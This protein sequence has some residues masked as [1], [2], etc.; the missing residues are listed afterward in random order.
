MIQANP[1]ITPDVLK[2][3][4]VGTAKKMGGLLSLGAAGSGAGLIDATAAVNASAA[5][6]YATK[7]AN[8]DLLSVGSTGAGPIQLSRDTSTIVY[9]DLNADG[10]L[11]SVVGEVDA[12]GNAWLGSTWTEVWSDN[13]WA[14]YVLEAI[15]WDGKTWGGKTWGGTSWKGKTWGGK[16]WS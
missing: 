15:G 4:L 2:A 3:T 9:S 10:S 12:L 1:S 11:D 5:D 6:A 16:A 14:P 7:P 13:P 8:R